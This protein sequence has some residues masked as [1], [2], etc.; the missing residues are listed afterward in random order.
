MIESFADKT[1]EKIFHGIHTHGVRIGFTS[2]ELKA[3][4]R[5]LDVLNSAD[6]LDSLRQIPRI[7]EEA[8][9]RDAHGK[10]SIPVT[11]EHRI[12][13]GWNSGP[14]NVEIKS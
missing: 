5:M 1:T 13:F 6:S 11:K 3:C 10:Y 7:K 8:S 2:G 9:V 12:A 14:E 4:V